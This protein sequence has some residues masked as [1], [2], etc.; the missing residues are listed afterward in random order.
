MKVVALV[1]IKTNNERLPNKNTKVFKNGRPL[2]KYIQETLKKVQ[3]LDEIYIFCSDTSIKEYLLPEV[4]F[5]ERSTR[6]DS[7]TTTSNDIL[8]SFID[9]VQADIYILAHATS[10]FISKESIER[11][12]ENVIQNGYDSALSVKKIQDFL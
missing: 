5:L 10:P 7:P 6:L 8:K 3:L 12:L 2:I 9:E 11:G 4:C 1:P